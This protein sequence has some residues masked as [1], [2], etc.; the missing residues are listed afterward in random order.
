MPQFG[1]GNYAAN[2]RS[3][4]MPA[5]LGRKICQQ[6]WVGKYA[7]NFGS[8]DMPAISGRKICRSFLVEK[9]CRQCQIGTKCQQ[10][11]AAKNSSKFRPEKKMPVFEGGDKIAAKPANAGE[12]A[13]LNNV[14]QNKK[15][16]V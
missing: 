6:F 8:E 5:I 1:V 16:L 12:L 3:E 14:K 10:I 9:K 7:G 15:S 13:G 11:P 2:F 4:D